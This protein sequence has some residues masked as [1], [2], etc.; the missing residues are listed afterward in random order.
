MKFLVL[1]KTP[2]SV[3]DTWMETDPEVRKEME[4]KMGSEWN[5][6]LKEHA[7]EVKETSGA[8]KPKVV[9]KDGVSDSRNDIMMYSILEAD[10]P[11]A[12]VKI[13]ENHSHLQIPEASIEIMP[14][15]PLT[16]M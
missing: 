8:G 14:A 15:N 16:E 9:T 4:S 1:Y 3:L 6:W 5:A 2:A 10:S 11:E 13:F 12:A 7:N